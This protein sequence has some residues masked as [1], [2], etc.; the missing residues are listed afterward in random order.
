MPAKTLREITCLYAFEF[1][2]SQGE[3]SEFYK[4]FFNYIEENKSMLAEDLPLMA[5][6]HT[7]IAYASFGMTTS[8]HADFWELVRKGAAKQL[9]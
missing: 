1:S 8:D 3:F 9:L 2:R 7:A 5:I 6:A 4:R